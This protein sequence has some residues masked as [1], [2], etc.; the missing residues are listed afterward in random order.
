MHVEA[1]GHEAGETDDQVDGQGGDQSDD[2]EEAEGHG[3]DAD[4]AGAMR[5]GRW[6][7]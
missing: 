1:G 5:K 7:G 2:E 4:E 3:S 6:T